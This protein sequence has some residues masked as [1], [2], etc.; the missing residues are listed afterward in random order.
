[1]HTAAYI[2]TSIYKA[3]NLAQRDYSKL[4]VLRSCSKY[5]H[6]AGNNYK[7]V[8]LQQTNSKKPQK[9]VSA[10]VNNK[11]TKQE[12]NFG[13]WKGVAGFGGISCSLLNVCNALYFGKQLFSILLTNIINYGPHY[14]F[15]IF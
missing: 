10:I 2:I 5:K 15:F 3:Q 9:S 4:L 11:E 13:G 12:N 7:L 8:F 6:I 1:M 14:Q